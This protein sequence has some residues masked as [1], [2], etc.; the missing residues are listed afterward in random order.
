MEDNHLSQVVKFLERYKINAKSYALYVRAL[1]HS[2]YANEHRI[3]SNYQR[4]EFLGDAFISWVVADHLYKLTMFFDK[5]DTFKK[6]TEGQMTRIRSQF[7]NSSHLASISINTGLNKLILVGNGIKLGVDKS[8]SKIYEDVYEAFVGAI[9]QDAGFEDASRFVI[10]TL[11]KP[12]QDSELDISK[13]YKTQFQELV[14]TIST[15][16]NYVLTDDGNQKTVKLYW[17]KLEYGIGRGKNRK[18]AEMMAAKDAYEKLVDLNSLN[19]MVNEK[20]GIVQ[21]KENKQEINENN[22]HQIKVAA[23]LKQRD[24]KQEKSLAKTN[25]KVKKQ[26]HNSQPK[27][28]KNKQELTK[29]PQ[30]NVIKQSSSSAKKKQKRKKNRN[31]SGQVTTLN[32]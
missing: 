9:T 17:N 20:E 12:I 13:D 8:S 23:K 28:V 25:N 30:Q 26:Q 18:E 4:L 3:K 14:Q 29:K 11:I 10:D 21:Y 27:D 7:V 6:L 19:Q 1:T 22:E 31:K 16:I 5:T 2:S 24:K 15:S 32:Q